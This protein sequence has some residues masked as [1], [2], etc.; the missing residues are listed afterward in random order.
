MENRKVEK[1]WF[2]TVSEEK[3]VSKKKIPTKM[4]ASYIS[5][6][7]PFSKERFHAK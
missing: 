2:E 3:K 7:P 4:Y 5:A 1:K 6:R